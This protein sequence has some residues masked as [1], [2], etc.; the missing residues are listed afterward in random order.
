MVMLKMKVLQDMDLIH[1]Q[2][3]LISFQGPLADPDDGLD[4][5]RDG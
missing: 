4:N 5:D 3:E 2:L 1:L